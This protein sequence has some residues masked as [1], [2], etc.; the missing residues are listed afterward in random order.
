M[1]IRVL[2]L[3]FVVSTV[4]CGSSDTGSAAPNEPDAETIKAIGV[5][6][7]KAAKGAPVSSN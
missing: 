4:G 7:E 1:L 6:Q 5:E 2:L 3:I